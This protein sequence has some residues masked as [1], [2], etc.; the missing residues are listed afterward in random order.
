MSDWRDGWPNL[1][2]DADPDA[3]PGD[4]WYLGDDLI[5]RRIRRPADF[6]AQALAGERYFLTLGLTA[7]EWALPTPPV[8]IVEGY[9]TRYGVS[10]GHD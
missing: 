1:P 3:L 10:S 4:M 9:G 2:Y 5:W 6:A 7:P 8:A